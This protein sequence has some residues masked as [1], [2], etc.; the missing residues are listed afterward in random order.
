MTARETHLN[1]FFSFRPPVGADLRFAGV[2]Y[3][4]QALAWLEIA[5]RLQ[6]ARAASAAPW[7][8]CFYA[9]FVSPGP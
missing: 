2:A 3:T 4:T 8:R 6:S 1:R 5:R 7:D 9:L